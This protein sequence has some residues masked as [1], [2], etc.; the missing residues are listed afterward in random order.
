MENVRPR[1]A[2]TSSNANRLYCD[3]PREVRLLRIL[4]ERG[5]VSRHAL[6]PAIGAENSPD[7]VFRLRRKG[8]EIPCERRKFIDRDG[9]TVRIGIYS[10]TPND[11]QKAVA[12]LESGGGV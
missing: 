3:N 12:G 11:R 5:E 2:E 8:F 7:V 10:M 1:Q 4:L 6:D 9:K